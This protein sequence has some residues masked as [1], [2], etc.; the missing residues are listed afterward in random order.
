MTKSIVNAIRTVPD[1]R[2]HLAARRA[3]GSSVGFVPTMGALHAGHCALIEAAAASH[4]EVV[5][6]IFVNPTQFE[7]AADLERYPRTEQA[8]IEMAIAAGASVCFIPTVDEIYPRG[9]ATTVS[10]SGGLSNR[11]EGAE[12]G[13][14]HFDG[15]ATVVTVLLNICQPDAAYFGEKDA[16]QLLVV[17]RF[18]TDLQIPTKIVAVPTVRSADGLALSSRN[19]RLSDQ[20]TV[21]ALAIARALAAAAE[22]ISDGTAGSPEEAET[23]GRAILDDAGIA[24]EYFEVTSPDTLA[25]AE[26]LDGELLISCAARV[27]DVRLIDNTTVVANPTR[28]AATARS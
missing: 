10:V 18:V 7:D 13:S 17:R 12:R 16:Q 20:E 1:L 9:A 22:A 11:L 23:T 6:S 21:Q 27:G 5:V 4:G 28:E 24:C 25:R 19:Q 14:S 15:V 26:R 3:D 2:E 8:D